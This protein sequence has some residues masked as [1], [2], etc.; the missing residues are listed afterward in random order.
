MLLIVVKVSKY[1]EILL[2]YLMYCCVCLIQIN[3]GIYAANFLLFSLR[4]YYYKL[5]LQFNFIMRLSTRL[6]QLSEVIITIMNK[7]SQEN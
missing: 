2:G 6:V 5:A 1:I 3:I 4:F 7:Y